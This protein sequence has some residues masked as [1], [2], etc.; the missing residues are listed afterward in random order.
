MKL[1][2]ISCIKC[3]VCYLKSQHVVHFNQFLYHK[4]VRN[5]KAQ[6]KRLFVCFILY[7]KKRNF[8]W[9][10]FSRKN[11]LLKL[12]LLF[13]YKIVFSLNFNL[14][15]LHTYLKIFICCVVWHTRIYIIPLV[16]NWM[17][18]YQKK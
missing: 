11:F 8:H 13:L 7:L 16:R 18:S 3:A 9:K 6:G 10:K 2:F 5:N 4:K 14:F 17:T 1:S 15:F 12:S